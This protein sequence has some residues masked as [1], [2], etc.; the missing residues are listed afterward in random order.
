MPGRTPELS[1]A[2]GF[3]IVRP[4]SENPLCKHENFIGVR[5]ALFDKIRQAVKSSNHQA[6][7]GVP[8]LLDE[9]LFRDAG[10]AADT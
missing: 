1:G 9:S 6:G 7:L 5:D 10:K 3:R 4:P 8:L 2:F